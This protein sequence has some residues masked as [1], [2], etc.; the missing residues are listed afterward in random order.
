V[1]R[2]KRHCE[3]YTIDD[4]SFAEDV[5]HRNLADESILDPQIGVWI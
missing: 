3:L 2:D 4:T 1:V 5:E